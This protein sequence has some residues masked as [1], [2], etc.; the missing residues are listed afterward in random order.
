MINDRAY[1]DRIILNGKVDAVN[2]GLD[3]RVPLTENTP[4]PSHEGVRLH[5]FR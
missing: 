4:V 2:V 5:R 1:K 3:L